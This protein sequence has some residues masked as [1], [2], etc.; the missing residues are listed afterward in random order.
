MISISRLNFSY[1]N[2]TKAL[3]D[4]SM[5]LPREHVL[6]ILGESGSGKTTLLRCIG[7][8]L[9]S[10]KGSITLDDEPIESIPELKF[11]KKL[12]IVFQQLYLFPHLSCLEN[13]TLAS[14]LTGGEEEDSANTNAMQMMHK[15]GIENLSEQYPSQISGGQAQR[16]A[17]AR[18]LMLNPEYLL[19]DEPTSALDVRTTNQFAEWL[20]ELK[21]ETTFIAVTH[22]IPFAREVAGKGV[23]LAHGKVTA[24]GP[25][26]E[27]ADLTTDS[28][29]VP[30]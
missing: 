23:M 26:N 21:T 1:S 18:S 5:D 24:Q 22:D 15:L 4:V 3:S 6:A 7:R 10:P 27:I 29:L 13:L 28:P 9:K 16:V 30:A 12:G 17:I 19:L 2:G 14:V 25:I 20:A 8:F 11:R